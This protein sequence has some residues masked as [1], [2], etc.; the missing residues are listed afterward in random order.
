MAQYV[1]EVVRVEQPIHT[2]EVARRVARAWGAQRTGARIKNLVVKALGAAK[3]DGRL[4]SEPFWMIPGGTVH[5]R[6]RSTVSSSALRQPELLPPAEVDLAIVQ[7]VARSVAI[8]RDEVAGCVGTALGFAATS[9]QLRALVGERVNHL[10]SAGQITDH[11]DLL[12][13]RS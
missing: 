12:R 2:D 6:D 3:V 11:D 10:L 8:G 5:V 9:A 1:V 7:A 13:L 4:T